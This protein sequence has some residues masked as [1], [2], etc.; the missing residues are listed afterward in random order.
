MSELLNMLVVL[1]N[2]GIRLCKAQLETEEKSRDI[3]F[4]QGR[5]AGYKA[6]LSYLEKCFSLS[7]EFLE[8][9]NEKPVEIGG[10][11][12]DELIKLSLVIDGLSISD[13]WQEVIE[14]VA[15][16]RERLKLFLLHEAENARDLYVT[17]ARHAAMTCFENLFANI[18]EE[19]KKRTEELP[20]DGGEDSGDNAA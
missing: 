13:E 18:K 8:D 16:E 9:N 17:Q 2:S 7:G 6:L 12:T 4:L 15:G 3:A 10:L 20:F 11:S 1:I 14:H 5:I 19:E